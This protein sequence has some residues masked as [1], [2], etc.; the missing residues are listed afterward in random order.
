MLRGRAELKVKSSG[1]E[2]MPSRI[3]VGPVPLSDP[4]R[5][6]V[7][8]LRASKLSRPVALSLLQSA[9]PGGAGQGLWRGCRSVDQRLLEDAALSPGA[10]RAP[11]APQE[12]SENEGFI[13]AHGPGKKA[14]ERLGVV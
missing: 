12:F 8:V 2:G 7:T 9:W 5:H 13:P 10:L 11:H 4:F 6:S 3:T 14:G 1:G